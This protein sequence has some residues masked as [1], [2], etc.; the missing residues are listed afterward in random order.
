MWSRHFVL[1]TR[2]SMTMNVVLFVKG[3]CS[4]DRGYGYAILWSALVKVIMNVG[5]MSCKRRMD[6][7]SFANC[8]LHAKPGV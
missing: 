6:V 8:L 5:K 4:G 7:K 3:M 2:E 1:A